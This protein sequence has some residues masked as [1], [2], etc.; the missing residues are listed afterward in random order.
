MNH[1]HFYDSQIK[2]QP[3]YDNPH[4]FLPFKPP[5]KIIWNSC[6]LVI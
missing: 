6:Y 4:K 5:Q 1:P 3:S 2:S